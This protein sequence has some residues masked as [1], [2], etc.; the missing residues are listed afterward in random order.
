MSKAYG[1]DVSTLY[2]AQSS[3]NNTST[4]YTTFGP[5]P[6]YRITTE[7]YSGDSSIS[8]IS[9][10]PN[11]TTIDDANVTL[12]FYEDVDGNW[13]LSPGDINLGGS[14]TFTADNTETT[15]T[16]STPFVTE[17][18]ASSYHGY[19]SMLIVANGTGVNTN[20]FSVTV[21]NTADFTCDDGDNSCGSGGT[22]GAGS[23]VLTVSSTAPSIT[24]ANG[25]NTPTNISVGPSSTAKAIHQVAFVNSS[26][27]SEIITSIQVT[28]TGNV[29]ENTDY[30]LKIWREGA[31]GT[32]GAVDGNDSLLTLTSGAWANNANGTTTFAITGGGF[33]VAGSG[34]TNFLFGIAGN[35]SASGGETHGQS[36]AVSGITT[37]SGT[38]V[39]LAEGQSDPLT[40]NTATVD[41]TPPS[42]TAVYSKSNYGSISVDVTF[43]EPIDDSTYSYIYADFELDADQTNDGVNEYTDGGSSSTSVTYPS[44]DSDAND[45]YFNI[46]GSGG[47]STTG[48]IYV[49]YDG[50]SV[51]DL[52]G[53]S[54]VA[55][56][57]CGTEYDAAQPAVSDIVG[58]TDTS[59]RNKFTYTFSENIFFDNTNQDGTIDTGDTEIGESVTSASNFGAFGQTIESSY[60]L[61]EGLLKSW[62]TGDITQPVEA[63]NTL[64][65]SAATLTVT[66]NT[67]PGCYFSGTTWPSVESMV[68]IDNMMTPNSLLYA[69]DGPTLASRQFTTNSGKYIFSN[70]ILN[71]DTTAPSTVTAGSVTAGATTI[72]PTWTPITDTHFGEYIIA[73]RTTT[74]VNISNGTLWSSANDAALATATTASTTI[75][76]LSGSTS[77]FYVVYAR[78]A[79]GNLSVASS[80]IETATSLPVPL[81]SGA[82]YQDS[83]GNGQVDKIKL[84]FDQ[85]I[86]TC[87]ATVAD[88]AYTA[89]SITN[90]AITG[91]TVTCAGNDT[92][93]YI[94]LG[95]SGGPNITSHSSA[96]TLAY[97]DYVSREISNSVNGAVASFGS[98][99][100]TDGAGP[101]V[102]SAQ[103]KDND[104]TGKIDGITISYSE[105]LADTASGANGFNVTSSSNHGTCNTEAADPSASS[106]L[107][108]T[109]VCSG[110]NT[111]VGD[112]NLVFTTNSGIRDAAGVQSP[113]VTLTT[114]SSP[115]ITD[116]AQPVLVSVTKGI[117]SN[118][119]KVTL[120]YSEPMYLDLN[121]SPSDMAGH[122]D[123]GDITSSESMTST[124]GVGGIS[125]AGV[126]RKIGS[127]RTTG[128]VLQNAETNNTVAVS[129]DGLTVTVTLNDVAGSYF[130]NSGTAPS[131]TFT[132]TDTATAPCV[133]AQTPNATTST[134]RVNVAGAAIVSSGSWDLTAPD[135]LAG[136]ATGSTGDGTVQLSWTAITPSSD[137]YSF[138]IYHKTS[139]GV[140]ISNGTGWTP[141]TSPNPLL[142]SAT[143]GTE[144]TGLVSGGIYYFAGYVSDIAGN[145]STV[146]SEVSAAAAAQGAFRESTPPGIPTEIK[147]ESVNGKPVLTWIDPT[148]RD[149]DRIEILRGINEIPVGGDPIASRS[150]RIQTF[151]DTTYE[152]KDGD[153]VK[154]ILRA[155]DSPGGNTGRNSAVVT[156]TIVG[157]IERQSAQQTTEQTTK[158]ETEQEEQQVEGQTQETNLSLTDEEKNLIKEKIALIE[159]SIKT[160]DKVLGLY[161]IQIKKL[162]INKTK[163]KTKIAEIKSVMRRIEKNKAKQVLNLNELKAKLEIK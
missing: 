31:A 52:A 142:N 106:T 114:S 34:T 118:K 160:I 140:T 125:S 89:G 151:T 137:F 120:V 10:T 42:I 20:T 112:M 134:Q 63:C 136:F 110:T 72:T 26:A 80:E 133:L 135:S 107:N 27:T 84:T 147:V 65:V 70:Q 16:F 123:D 48:L 149:L 87:T 145:V 46:Y 11:S 59:G 79:A 162:S 68:S 53:N 129:A 49:H 61:I 92:Y 155:K 93:V 103:I 38:T 50:T 67:Q 148:D 62:G 29:E 9:V 30:T 158:Q 139:A 132:A 78:D 138:K 102:V 75:T 96:P 88:F 17:G 130:T 47:P 60:W 28:P 111:A 157:I 4:V 119:N 150:K 141:A 108:L 144:I 115:S 82:A 91:G 8:A 21:P 128:T 101:V 121:G 163:N 51:K 71:W 14:G 95:T 41:A 6:V 154:Y 83:D 24:V 159:K 104:N 13:D 45:E 39:T 156:V 100:V 3:I 18:P 94:N 55:C 117:A 44:I 105:S 109:F 66:F 116:G 152:F 85:T 23:T 113:T 37:S 146:S 1:P 54:M 90:S 58:A 76:G 22:L 5:I 7:T 122:I 64:S 36:V 32:M 56:N 74:G 19:G 57:A 97:T 126:I 99:N 131:S 12:S 25:S 124:A 77:Y 86:N 161:N 2:V 153:I 69:T 73:Y 127:F 15:F 40:S 35:G 33:R 143:I 98:Q 43:S 81:L